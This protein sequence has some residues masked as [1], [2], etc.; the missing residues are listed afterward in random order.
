M[1]QLPV[2]T[3]K[4]CSTLYSSKQARDMMQSLKTLKHDFIFQAAKEGIK[5]REI[6]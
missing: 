2:Q 5:G 4:S 1:I 3:S 6:S